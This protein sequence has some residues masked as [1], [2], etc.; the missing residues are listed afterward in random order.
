MLDFHPQST[1]T[2]IGEAVAYFTRMMK[3]RTTAFVISDF[4]DN[5]DFLKQFQIA[6]N[7]HDLMAVQVYDRWAKQLPDVGLMKRAGCRNG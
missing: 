5:K 1:K 6:N 4:Y 2:D 3:R 7:K